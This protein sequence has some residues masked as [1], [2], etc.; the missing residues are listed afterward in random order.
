MNAITYAKDG[1]TG[2]GASINDA[3]GTV[4]AAIDLTYPGGKVYLI[5][6][7][8][9]I[10][11]DDIDC[12]N[13]DLEGIGGGP[14][15]V[16]IASDSETQVHINFTDCKIKGV[17]L[18]ANAD[19][20]GALTRVIFEDCTVDLDVLV[21]TIDNCDFINCDIISTGQVTSPQ[22]R[23]ARNCRISIPFNNCNVIAPHIY[24]S[25][26]LLAF[27][28]QGGDSSHR[29]IMERCTF[30]DDFVSY[31]ATYGLIRDCTYFG[32]NDLKSNITEI[33]CEQYAKDTT[34][35]KAAVIADRLNRE[36]TSRDENGNPLTYNVGTGDNLLSIAV[37][38]EEVNG[39]QKCKSETIPN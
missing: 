5:V 8:T 18:T 34:V 1:A 14:G 36:V 17:K 23:E 29:A 3:V 19:N 39:L 21:I 25:L 37:E 30:F 4:D 9:P 13:V 11:F 16:E 15:G 38:Y 33:N 20:I 28:L 6:G 24:D 2:S 32:T 10:P 26:F 31:Q 27:T 35:A 22:I 7:A 12:T